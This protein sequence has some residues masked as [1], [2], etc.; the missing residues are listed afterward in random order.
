MTNPLVSVIIPTY[1]YG[2]LIGETLA[3]LAKQTYSNWECLVIDD[4]STDETAAE[5]NIFITAHAALN[6]QYIPL[7]NGGTSAAKN[8]GIELAK[9]EL[10]QFLDADDLLS[11]DKLRIQVA[12]FLTRDVALVFSASHFFEMKEGVS[13]S[14]QKYPQGYL[15]TETLSGHSL[16][17]RLVCNNII[18]ISSPLVQTKL[19]RAAGGFDINLRNNE[20]WIL[21]FRIALLNP[22]FEFDGDQQSYTEIRIHGH[23]AMTRHR[24]MFLGEVTVRKQMETLLKDTAGTKDYSALIKLN[25]DLLALHQIRSLEVSKGFHWIITSFTKKPVA[26]YKLLFKGCYKLMVR[27]YKNVW[28]R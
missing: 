12:A 10:I 7:S 27:I 18:T 25:K 11:P 28:D 1:N 24:E 23:S 16:L 5:V 6:I 3:S 26:E 8:T 17:K 19:I 20:D 22:H 13:I 9:G 21:W 15:A 4:G 14:L 2:H